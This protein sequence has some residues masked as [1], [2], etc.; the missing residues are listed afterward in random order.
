MKR[1]TGILATAVASV[2]LLASN[3][4]AAKTLY[5]PKPK[6]T[7]TVLPSHV[8]RTP[9]QA[10]AFTGANIAL[11]LIVLSVLVVAGL[12]AVRMA[13]RRATARG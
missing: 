4:M 11:G 2:V 8:V 10:T 9:P 6:P 3:A 5:P 12:I 7:P 13:N 1:L